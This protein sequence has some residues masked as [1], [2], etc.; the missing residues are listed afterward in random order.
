MTLPVSIQV[1]WP[2]AL[3]A[4]IPLVIWWVARSRHRLVRRHLLVAAVLRGLALV[5][6]A[7]ALMRPLWHAE[8]ADVS[9]VYALDVSRSVSPAFI[10]SAIKWIGLANGEA[11]PAAARYV[12]FADRAILLQR[13]EDLRAVAVREG[14]TDGA[15]ADARVLDQSATNLERALETA[16]L[17]LDG[18]RAKRIVLLTDGN[19]T[20]G[21]LWRVLPRLARAH[22]RVYPIPAKVRDPRDVGIARID[23]PQAVNAAEPFSVTVRVVCAFDAPARVVLRSERALLG[24]RKVQLKTGLN[25]IMFETTLTREGTNTLS[26]ERIA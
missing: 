3:A 18:E 2:G 26:A 15:A 23:M 6:L 24:S 21:D 9:V 4:I 8:S 10:D 11:R 17:G 25:G 16:L 1:A 7:L 14:P 13:P 22:V 20:A 12:A 19:Q 5:S